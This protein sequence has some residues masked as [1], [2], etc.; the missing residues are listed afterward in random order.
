[1][2]EMSN[3]FEKYNMSEP[4]RNIVHDL[5]AL[6]LTSSTRQLQLTDAEF[7]SLQTNI[8]N[9]ALVGEFGEPIQEK[10]EQYDSQVG[11]VAKLMQQFPNLNPSL[12]NITYFNQATNGVISFRSRSSEA[13]KSSN[14]SC[15]AVRYDDTNPPIHY[16]T[17][18]FFFRVMLNVEDEKKFYE[19]ASVEWFVEP[20]SSERW[21]GLTVVKYEPLHRHNTLFRVVS[22]SSIELTE[23]IIVQPKPTVNEHVVLHLKKFQA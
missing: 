15:M 23:V 3:I 18:H 5:S 2:V 17:A 4:K 19:F 7:K 16:C 20:K 13:H 14:N 1:M 8:F 6:H 11:G 10:A 22:L 21:H 9:L 12:A